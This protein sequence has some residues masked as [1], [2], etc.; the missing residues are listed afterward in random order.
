VTAA[1]ETRGSNLRV[2]EAHEEYLR[3]HPD[4]A[5]ALDVRRP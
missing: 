5:G 3:E 1:G 4:E 2:A